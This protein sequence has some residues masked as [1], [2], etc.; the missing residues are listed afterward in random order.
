MADEKEKSPLEVAEA[1]R[2][3]RKASLQAAADAQKAI[4][5]EAIDEIEAE[6]GDASIKAA[7]LPGHKPGLVTKVAVRCPT[8]AEITRYRAMTKP[9]K[10]G[11]AA[12]GAVA[13]EALGAVC[14]VYPVDDPGK[15]GESSAFDAVCEAFPGVLAQCGMI[16]AALAIADEEAEG[17]G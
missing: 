7:D 11:R 15:E 13:N 9:D 3:A 8:K 17:K 16:A 12:D 6:L 10:K 2:A 4:D 14:R 5:T 1:K